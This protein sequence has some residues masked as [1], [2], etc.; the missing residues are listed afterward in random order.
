MHNVCVGWTFS[1]KSAYHITLYFSSAVNLILKLK[2]F[3]WKAITGSY[4]LTEFCVQ[5]QHISLL[6]T[7]L[8]LI[9]TQVL[10]FLKYTV[11]Q[12]FQDNLSFW[13][14]KYKNFQNLDKF[15]PYLLLFKNRFSKLLIWLTGNYKKNN[16]LKTGFYKAY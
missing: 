8:T 9:Y 10:L 5:A 16:W 15:L 1:F 12:S 11:K 3:N 2:P 7:V 13:Y 4:R 14:F 6:M